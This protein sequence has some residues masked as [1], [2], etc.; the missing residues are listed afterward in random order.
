MPE[1]ALPDVVGTDAETA[2]KADS[3]TV[4]SK[5]GPIVNASANGRHLCVYGEVTFAQSVR[6]CDQPPQ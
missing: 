5:I 3:S 1:Q 6:V 2:D 4:C